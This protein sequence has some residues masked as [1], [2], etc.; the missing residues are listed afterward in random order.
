MAESNQQQEA[1]FTYRYAF[2]PQASEA[3]YPQAS[4]AYYPPGDEFATP[5]TDRQDK[6]TTVKAAYH[7]RAVQEVYRNCMPGTAWIMTETAPDG[8]ERELEE[9][10]FNARMGWV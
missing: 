3:Y 2:Y 8:T 7:C 4:E 1:T 5:C 9:H 10:E 6:H